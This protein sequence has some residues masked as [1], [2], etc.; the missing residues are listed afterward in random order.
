MTKTGNDPQVFRYPDKMK[1]ELIVWHKYPDIEPTEALD[2]SFL[3]DD[4]EQTFFAEYKPSWKAFYWEGEPCEV[5]AWANDPK[6]WK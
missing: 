5:I 2:K 4:G 1:Q 3:V 6:G